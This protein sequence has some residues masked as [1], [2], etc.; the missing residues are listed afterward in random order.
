MIGR[1]Q[2]VNPLSLF[3]GESGVPYLVLNQPY[4]NTTTRNGDSGGSRSDGTVSTDNTPTVPDPVDASKS[5]IQGELWLVSDETLS[6]LDDY[7]G[8]SKSYYIRREEEVELVEQPKKQEKD[9]PTAVA[10]LS[11]TPSQEMSIRSHEAFDQSSPVSS[12]SLTGDDSDTLRRSFTQPLHSFTSSTTS[13]RMKAHVYGL[14]R[15][16]KKKP[17]DVS[18]ISEYTLE[19]HR[20]HYQPIRHIQV[21]QQKH[22]QEEVGTSA[23]S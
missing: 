3:V 19:F 23:E 2:T 10:A 22:L 21:K 5:L 14:V 1:A 4:R 20:E 7:E 15:M 11:P 12:E 8:I 18:Y 13:N 6:G 17:E 16:P 9:T